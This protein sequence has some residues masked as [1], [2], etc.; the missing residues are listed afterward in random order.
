[1]LNEKKLTKAE[2]DKREEIIM[3]MKKNKRSLVDKY[4]KDAEAVMYGRATNMAKKQAESMKNDRLSELIKDSLTNPK[5]ADLNK[6]GK[7]S[8]YEKTRGKAIE[9][10]MMKETLDDEVFA[11]VDRMVAMMG[12]EDVVDAIVRAMSTDDARLYL[13]A[14]MKDYDINEVGGYDRKGNKI[15][16]PSDDGIKRRKVGIGNALKEEDKNVMSNIM[17]YWD[18]TDTMI[19]DLREFILAAKDAG[20]EDLVRE[21]ADALKLMTNYAIGEYKKL[22]DVSLREEK[23]EKIVPSQPSDE[24]VI[25]II[26]KMAPKTKTKFLKKLAKLK[27]ING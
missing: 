13:G 11:M 20:G 14:I 4:G 19:N 21:I 8:D 3:K 2:L 23:E 9:K 25:D 17:Q 5:K 6:D 22:G 7:L 26:K 10:S 15:D 24:R 16:T 27:D 12:A 1:M 18:R